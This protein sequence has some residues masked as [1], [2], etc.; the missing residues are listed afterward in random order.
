MEKYEQKLYFPTRYD[1]S[2]F[3]CP[4]AETSGRTIWSDVICLQF[5]SLTDMACYSERHSL[6]NVNLGA[7]LH[8]SNK[9][10][11]QSDIS[12]VNMMTNTYTSSLPTYVLLRYTSLMQ[13]TTFSNVEV[14]LNK[15]RRVIC[16]RCA[17]LHVLLHE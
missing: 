14:R 11:Q 5:E 15:A 6:F 13:L 17:T 3:I 12:V 4:R 8:Y 9:P 16:L 10:P 7:L 1:R 2:P